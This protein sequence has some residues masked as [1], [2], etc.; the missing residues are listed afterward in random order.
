MKCSYIFCDE[1]ETLLLVK[2]G[3]LPCIF[4]NHDFGESLC[5]VK[6]IFK[7]EILRVSAS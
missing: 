7:C 5:F 2:G 6:T 4:V 3:Q 1:E